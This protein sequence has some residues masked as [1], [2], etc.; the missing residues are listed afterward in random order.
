MAMLDVRADLQTSGLSAGM[1]PRKEP[2]DTP[3]YGTPEFE[4]EWHAVV[5]APFLEKMR[6]EAAEQAIDHI[7]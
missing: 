1:E 5:V 2:K 4:A 6:R 7:Q 3:K